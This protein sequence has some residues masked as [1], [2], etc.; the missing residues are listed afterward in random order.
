MRRRS[1]QPQR[2]RQRAAFAAVI[3][4]DGGDTHGGG[5][6]MSNHGNCDQWRRL[7]EY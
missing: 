7:L 6:G 3:N 2:V 4:D 5:D 1:E